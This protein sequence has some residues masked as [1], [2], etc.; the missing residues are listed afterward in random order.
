MC[1]NLF[2]TIPGRT[3]RTTRITTTTPEASRDEPE[4]ELHEQHVERGGVCRDRHHY[5]RGLLRDPGLDHAVRPLE[6]TQR[7]EECGAGDCG[8]RGSA[9]DMHHHCFGDPLSCAGA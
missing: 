1:R 7:R 4:S 9:G 2:V 5:L 8:G 6:G 3:V